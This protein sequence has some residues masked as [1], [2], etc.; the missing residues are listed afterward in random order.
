MSFFRDIVIPAIEKE[1]RVLYN[2]PE[3]MKDIRT[4]E[5]I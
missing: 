3:Y 1:F 4:P 2:T 5:S